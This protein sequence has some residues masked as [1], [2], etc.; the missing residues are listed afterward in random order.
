LVELGGRAEASIR[1]VGVLK[2][3]YIGL[4]S[5][6]VRALEHDVL[7]PTEAEPAES[8]EDRARALLGAASLVGVFDAQQELAAVVLDVQPVEERGAGAP[9]VEI[10]RGRW[11]EAETMGHGWQ[12]TIRN[13]EH[14]ESPPCRGLPA[15][16]SREG[17]D[18]NPRYGFK[19]V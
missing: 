17:R 8:L 5:R 3:S 13:A 7:V 6:Q 1:G 9:D 4:M 11:S 19:P 12:R 16:S 2:P 15:I 18:S 10:A 14:D